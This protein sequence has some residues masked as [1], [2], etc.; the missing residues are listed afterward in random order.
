M[1]AQV[2]SLEKNVWIFMVQSIFGDCWSHDIYGSGN[3]PFPGI[4]D[5][6]DSSS[7]FFFFFF[8]WR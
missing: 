2:K 6:F 8:T 5:F 3:W 7:G 1:K 4:I